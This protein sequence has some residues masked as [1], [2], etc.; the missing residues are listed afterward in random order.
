MSYL[1][2]YKTLK[3]SPAAV[4]YLGTEPR[5]YEDVAPVG[6]AVPYVVWQELGGKSL[7]YVDNMPADNDDVMYQVKVYDTKANR[8]SEVRTVVRKVLELN[9]FIMNPRISGVDSK[10]NQ[11]FRGFD[12]SWIHEA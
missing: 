7:N 8:A 4:A 1:P 3:E 11:Y 12:A 2:I 5:V 10:T 6:A 9:S